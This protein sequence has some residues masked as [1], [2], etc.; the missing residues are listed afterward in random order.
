MQISLS[1]ALAVVFAA[2]LLLLAVLVYTAFLVL[3]RPKPMPAKAA[4]SP[5]VDPAVFSRGMLDPMTEFRRM[6]IVSTRIISDRRI[7]P[8]IQFYTPRPRDLG[9][10]QRYLDGSN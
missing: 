3:Q 2:F 7:E 6:A 10:T 1:L 8:A 9:F 5:R 4:S